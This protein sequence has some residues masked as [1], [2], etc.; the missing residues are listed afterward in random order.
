MTIR[1]IPTI[2]VVEDDAEN[3]AAMIKVLEAAGYKTLETDNGQ[4]AL[5]II[6]DEGVDILVTDL[7]LPIMDGVELLKNCLLR[8]LSLPGK[9]N[10]PRAKQH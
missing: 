8:N 5:D 2:L 1:K 3:R 10:I 7:R 9:R 4:Q 6:T